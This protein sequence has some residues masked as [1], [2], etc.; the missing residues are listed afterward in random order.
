MTSKR[1]SWIKTME[2]K[3]LRNVQGKTKRDRIRNQM[4]RMGLGMA[5]LAN[6]TE[7][8][9]LQWF[10]PLERMDSHRIPKMAW[11]ARTQKEE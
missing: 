1:Y 4:I 8:K 7:T 11:Q 9:Q 5:P 10:G 2:M 6:T 3:Y